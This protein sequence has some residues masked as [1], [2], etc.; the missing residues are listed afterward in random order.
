MRTTV[1]FPYKEF[2]SLSIDD[3][4]LIG[5]FGPPEGSDFPRESD[6]LRNALAHPIGSPSLA[7]ILEGKKRILVVTDD[8]HRPTP[9]DRM[10]PPVLE[11]IRRVGI[12][13]DRVEF[14]VA[15][16]SHRPMTGPELEKKL[17]AAVVGSYRVSNHDWTNTR[18]LAFMGKVPP[19]IE[20][21]VNGKMREFDAVIGL[22]SIMP[23]DVCGFTGGGKVIVPGLCGEKTNSDV[24]WVRTEVPSEAV[25]GR[26][27]NPVREAI[28]RAALAAGLTAVFNVVLDSRCRIAKAVFGQPVEAHREGARLALTAHSVRLPE[29]ADVVVAD[30]FPFDIEFWQANKALG[31]AALAVRDGGVII[32][33]SPCSDGLSV[34][35][36]EDLLRI[37]YRPSAEIRELVAGGQI[38]HLVVGVHMMQ[39]AQA[40]HDRGITCILV[41]PGISPEKLRAVNLGHAPD[42]QAA[43]ELALAKTGPRARV[44]V[45]RRAS[46]TLPL[47]V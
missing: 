20:V 5:V 3:A 23:I 9:V 47:R 7:G 22:G 2:P 6:I 33:V 12:P 41:T 19:G 4:N 40:T 32:L 17:G 36:E 27:D 24:H 11:E 13:P 10:I 31:H 28:D 42:P 16:G 1:T 25:I 38:P 43:L 8:H 26:R 29:I 44:A 35:H 45:L 15:L 14:V 21:W 18:S 30:S 34:T 46:E 39:V 37:G